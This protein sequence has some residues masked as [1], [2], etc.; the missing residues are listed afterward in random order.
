MID[1][2]GTGIKCSINGQL[3]DMYSTP[4]VNVPS[5]ILIGLLGCS[6]KLISG[7]EREYCLI[8]SGENQTCWHETE[9]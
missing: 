9:E 4:N 8:C 1:I 6:Q 3:D 7:A 2:L 5:H